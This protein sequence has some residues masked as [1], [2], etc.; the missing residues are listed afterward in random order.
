MDVAAEIQWSLLPPVAFTCPELSVVGHVEPCYEVGGDCFDYAYNGGFLDFALFDAMGHGLS[1]T[2]LSVLTVGVYRRSRRSG[3]S[4]TENVVAMDDT[5]ARIIG[6]SKFV[7]ALCG[8]LDASTGRVELVSAGHPRPLL[9][10][11]RGEFEELDLAPRRPLG[12]GG[13]TPPPTV[14]QLAERGRLVLYTDGMVDGRRG[15][16]VFGKQRL[17]ELI[18]GRA[19]DGDLTPEDLR[20]VTKMVEIF[21]GELRDDATTMI[22]ARTGSRA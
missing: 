16:E 2:L 9:L 12:L 14:V 3:L 13:D 7:T 22:V 8:R 20:Q 18:A 11:Q 5:I 6:D 19:L 21:A 15:R 17:Q 4:L 10:S 1:A